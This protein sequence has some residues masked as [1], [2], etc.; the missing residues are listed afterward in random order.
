MRARERLVGPAPRPGCNLKRLKKTYKA[1]P[2]Q[3]WRSRKARSALALGNDRAKLAHETNVA[4][5][6]G[7]RGDH[8]RGDSALQSTPLTPD[9]DHVRGD[10]ACQSTPE[11]HNKQQ[12]EKDNSKGEASRRSLLKLGCGADGSLPS[13]AAHPHHWCLARVT[14]ITNRFLPPRAPSIRWLVTPGPAS[15][16]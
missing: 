7:T 9:R 5:L 16:C 10:S 6:L 2:H 1:T 14:P 15:I 4:R 11:V 3:Q 13:S 12:K 8:V